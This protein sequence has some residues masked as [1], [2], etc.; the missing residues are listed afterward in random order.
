MEITQGLGPGLLWCVPSRDEG[1]SFLTCQAEV[2]PCVVS[3][4]LCCMNQLSKLLSSVYV[5]ETLATRSSSL[6]GPFWSASAGP[7]LP[8]GPGLGLGS[9]GTPQNDGVVAASQSGTPFDSIWGQGANTGRSGGGRGGEP[10]V[11][12]PCPQGS[13]SGPGTGTL[14]SFCSPSPRDPRAVQGKLLDGRPSV[15]LPQAETWLSGLRAG[16]QPPKGPCMFPEG[17]H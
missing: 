2:L 9:Q 16:N 3:F 6:S 5:T 12:P 17:L 15:A 11:R 8:P 1:L 4:R 7:Y 14:F 13:R 10:W